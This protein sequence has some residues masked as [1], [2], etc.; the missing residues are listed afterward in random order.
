M[1]DDALFAEMKRRAPNNP[2]VQAFEKKRK[3]P[4]CGSI[5]TESYP[6]AC[7]DSRKCLKCGYVWCGYY[8]NMS[9]KERLLRRNFF[10]EHNGKEESGAHYMW[11][12][13]PKKE[14]EKF[15]TE[16]KLEKTLK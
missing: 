14:I 16:Q 8:S 13:I 6:R 15:E 7:R 5:E 10:L 12:N 1:M 3:C 2:K 4:S 9:T 11:S